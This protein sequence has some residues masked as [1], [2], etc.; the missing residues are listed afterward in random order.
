MLLFV[1]N[2]RNSIP[3]THMGEITKI[4]IL[5]YNESVEYRLEKSLTVQT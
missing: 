2:P 1:V 5:F 3:L 4:A